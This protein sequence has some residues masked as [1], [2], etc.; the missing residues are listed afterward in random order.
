M[1]NVVGFFAREPGWNCLQQLHEDERYR[2]VGL[3]T[4]QLK[5]RSEDPLRGERTNFARFSRY[6]EQNGVPM[7]IKDTLAQGVDLQEI[8]SLGAI[9]FIVSCNWK[10]LIPVKVLQQARRG[11]I[12][13][14][15]GK[16]PE[17]RGLEP[18]RRSLEDGLTD[19]YIS[20]HLMDEEYDTGELVH[21]VK[22]PANL[23][24]NESLEQA[25]DRLKQELNPYYPVAMIKALDKLLSDG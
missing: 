8:F 13:L 2:V 25:V 21:E 3:F 16:L 6:V 24:E 22:I 10:F 12:N 15:R 1:Y 9:D 17:Y 4:H 14:H 19:A 23:S 7:F 18:I 5:P 11:A 20:A